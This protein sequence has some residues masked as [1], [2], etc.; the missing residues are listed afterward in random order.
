MTTNFIDQ[1]PTILIVDDNSTNLSVLASFLE[2]HH[3]TVLVAQ[4]GK[5]T[6][7]KVQYS[8]PD[9]IL[10]DVMLP[11]LNG[12]EIC[13]R[14]KSTQISQDIPVIFMTAL[15]DSEDVVKGF[16]V[17]AVDYITKPINLK[18]ALAR[19]TT[20]LHLQKLRYELQRELEERK[21]TEKALRER[22][23]EN[24]RLYKQSLKTAE[25]LRQ[26]D[27]IKSDFLANM[28]HELR[29]PLNSI[30]GYSEM[31]LMGVNEELSTE[32]GEDVQ[33]IFDNGHHLL[34][35][36]NNILDL[37]K[38]EAGH[39]NIQFEAM[40]VQTLLEAIKVNNEGLFMN[41]SLT[42]IV[43]A[44]KDLPMIK[45]DPIRITQILNNLI[46]N[47]MKFTPEGYVKLRAFQVEQR[48]CLEVE[49][50]GIGI[51]E[52]DLTKIF[53]KFQQV[54]DS[55]TRRSEGTGL[56][57]A[58]TQHLVAMHG[59]QIEVRSQL[60]QGTTFTVHLPLE[61]QETPESA[62]VALAM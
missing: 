23:K 28:S 59:G 31:M 41:Q 45:A 29:T 61:H 18:E 56:G 62:V 53:E 6:F 32:M 25:Q 19:L 47:A 48:V 46:S 54:D 2:D 34:K 43:E 8:Q 33:A 39:F 17:G 57:L 20:H 15:T 24:A 11:D 55:F 22:E 50:T 5:D 44:E 60:G 7:Q 9:L 27:Q 42:L 51:S 12:F 49:D 4:D 21:Q 38:I 30:I 52:E 58:I 13:R 36:I 10:L 35:V 16:E 1:D 40:E 26:L 37:A 3:F 14:L